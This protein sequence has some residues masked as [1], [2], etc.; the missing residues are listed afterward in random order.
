MKN[1]PFRTGIAIAFVIATLGALVLSGCGKSNRSSDERTNMDERAG[2]LHTEQQQ[3]ILEER[4]ADPNQVSPIFRATLAGSDKAPDHD[5]KASGRL[6]LTL[7]GDS[8]HIEGQFSGL[9]S[10]YTNSDIHRVLEAEKVQSLNPALKENKTAGSWEGSYKLNKDQ[11]SAL[12]GDSLFISVYSQ[13][14]E[15][16]EISGQ[17]NAVDSLS[18]P[19]GQPQ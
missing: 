16:S 9:S 8:I 10:A 11:I 15:A 3:Q 18:N 19:P 7:Q 13:G 1:Q 5:T 14:D 2:T 12:K 4:K 6:T 17:I